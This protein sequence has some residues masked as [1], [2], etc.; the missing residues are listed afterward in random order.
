MNF[1]R[2]EDKRQDYTPPVR[3]KIFF[4]VRGGGRNMIFDFSCMVFFLLQVAVIVRQL[5]F[6]L[7][8]EVLYHLFEINPTK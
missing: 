2:K 6:I 7:L 5:L 3:K 8:L 4:L 1:N